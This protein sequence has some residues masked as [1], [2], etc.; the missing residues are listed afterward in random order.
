MVAVGYE[1]ELPPI[2]CSMRLR[3]VLKVMSDP[4]LALQLGEIAD[5]KRKHR[6][7]KPFSI[8]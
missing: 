7:N 8:D 2:V 4:E 1:F 5:L 3:D 6:R